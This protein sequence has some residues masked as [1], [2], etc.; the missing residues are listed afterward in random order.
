M[1]QEAEV[2]LADTW[3]VAMSAAKALKQ[4]WVWLFEA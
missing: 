4:D 1:Q 3:S 2:S